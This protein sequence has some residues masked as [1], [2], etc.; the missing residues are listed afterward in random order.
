MSDIV[1]STTGKIKIRKA[2]VLTFYFLLTCDTFLN[3]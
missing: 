3:E 1:A 2:M